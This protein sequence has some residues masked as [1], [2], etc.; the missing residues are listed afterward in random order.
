MVSR[1]RLQDLARRVGPSR[2][3]MKRRSWL[4]W[5][6]FLC[7]FVG[8][9]AASLQWVL[10]FLVHS[11]KEVLVPDITRKTLEQAMDALSP[12]GLAVMKE[13]VEAQDSVPAGVIFRQ[14]PPAGLKVREGKIIRITVSSGGKVV[15]VPNL[16]QQSLVD[17]QNHLRASGLLLG[18]VDESYS[19]RYE[20][21]WVVGQAPSEG[22]VL[23]R[24][25]M[26]DLRLSKG[27]P[28]EGVLL[29]PDFVNRTLEEASRWAADNSFNPAVKE[30]VKSDVLPGMVLR[31][32]PMPDDE[33]SS[34]ASVQF[35]VSRSTAT[36]GRARLV[37]YQ[38][39]SGSETVQVRIVARSGD[40]EREIYNGSKEGGAWVEVP[41]L[42]EGVS[43]LQIFVN[44][45]LIEE[46]AVP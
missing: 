15:F 20:S 35:V 23:Q 42:L 44:G 2:G 5:F 8:V 12:L 25:K 41:A 36:T 7:I 18:A 45:V 46:Q 38:V 28:P 24:G 14:S 39:P 37:R 4:S 31:Q 17:A 32:K 9:T 11:R 22:S 26:V 34:G 27:P 30:E 10:S 29:M 1:A 16:L 21:G 6:I 43:R 33:L 19:T 3:V 40:H 13:G